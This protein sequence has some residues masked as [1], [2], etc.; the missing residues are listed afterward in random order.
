MK[1]NIK[2]YVAFLVWIPKYFGCK[3]AKVYSGYVD[4]LKGEPMLGL[5][6]MVLLT[7]VSFIIVALLSLAIL[8]KG[9]LS[10]TLSLILLAGLPL[11][12]LVIQVQRLYSI[13][14]EERANTFN[15]LKDLK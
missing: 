2:K 14:N 9:A 3:I 10:Q 1:I 11:H 15:S 7:I 4:L 5:L 8:G 13:F 12:Y 6:G